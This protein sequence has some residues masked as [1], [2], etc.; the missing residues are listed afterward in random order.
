MVLGLAA[1]GVTRVEKIAVPSMAMGWTCSV[2]LLAMAG[3]ACYL[4]LQHRRTPGWLGGAFAVVFLVGFMI[5]IVAGGRDT[6][7]S[8]SLGGLMAGSVTLA[9]P[10]VFGSL[11]GVLCE[12]V[13]VVN[14]AIEG[15][16]L[17]GAFSAAVVATMTG[18]RLPRT[19]LRS[20]GRRRWCPWCWPS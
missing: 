17:L 8:I 13:G 12:R 20:G 14:I 16:L 10:L 4:T 6:E 5:W 7:P 2:L 9:V 19:P 15:Q 1:L 3:Y 18:Q 11:S